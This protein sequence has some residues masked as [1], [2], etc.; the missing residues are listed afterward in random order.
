MLIL[1]TVAHKGFPKQQPLI[2]ALTTDFRLD[3]RRSLEEQRGW[4]N[5]KFQIFLK[6]LRVSVMIYDYLR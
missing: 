3:P 1:F 2:Q 5:E 6:G 4:N